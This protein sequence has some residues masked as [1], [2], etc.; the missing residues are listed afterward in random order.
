MSADRAISSI[1]AR[2]NPYRPKASKATARI[3]SCRPRSEVDGID[4]MAL[5]TQYVNIV[6]LARTR[7]GHLLRCRAGATSPR[8]MSSRAR[9]VANPDGLVHAARYGRVSP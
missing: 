8:G 6:K 1:D 2:R 7:R 4:A 3:L 5:L 9:S